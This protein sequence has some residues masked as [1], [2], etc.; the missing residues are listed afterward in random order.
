MA[1][2]TKVLELDQSRAITAGSEKGLADAIR[3]GADLR[4]DTELETA[5]GWQAQDIPL[6]IVYEDDTIVVVNKP[7]GLVVHP[8]AGHAEGTLVNALLAH[9]PEL[10][11]AILRADLSP[12]ASVPP[13]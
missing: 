9:A 6:D 3:R 5:V 4:I 12:T 13:L 2:W 11:H 1:Q 7:A 8:A 10:G